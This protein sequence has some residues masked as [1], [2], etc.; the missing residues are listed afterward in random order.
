MASYYRKNIRNF[1][2]EADKKIWYAVNSSKGREKS[3]V[4]TGVFV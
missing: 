3:R 4:Q 2:E 1:K